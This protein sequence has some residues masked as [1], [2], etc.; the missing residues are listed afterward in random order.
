MFILSLGAG[1]LTRHAHLHGSN[2]CLCQFSM[3]RSCVHIPR[4][5][6]P[7]LLKFSTG[8]DNPYYFPM[9]VFKLTYFYWSIVDSQCCVSF[10]CTAKWFHFYIIYTY[11]AYMIDIYIYH[12][13]FPGGAVV[14]NLPAN[15]GDARDVGQSVGWVDPLEEEMT[16]H[17][18]IL[19]WR[20]PWTK[21][22][23]RLQS[24]GS[25]RI[26]HVWMTEQAHAHILHIFFFFRLSSIIS[27]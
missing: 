26:R 16:T 21:E 12:I 2:W 5:A 13:C 8:M 4:K 9:S 3:S 27:Y 20:I 24:M 11:S 6:E 22:P 23:D 19:T 25:Q 18:I 10:R 17:S 1:S 15:A 7:L 14:K